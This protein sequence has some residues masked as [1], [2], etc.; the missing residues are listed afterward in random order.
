M[1]EFGLR[2]DFVA[3]GHAIIKNAKSE[4]EDAIRG[5]FL[6]EIKSGL[7]V[8]IRNKTVLAPWKLD[9]LGMLAALLANE[10]KVFAEGVLAADF[11]P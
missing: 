7:C 6:G 10:L 3:K 4:G 2:R 1:R 8:V 11:K 5:G 9:G